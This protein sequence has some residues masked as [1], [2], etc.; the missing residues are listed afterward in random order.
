L[1][2]AF[3]DHFPGQTPDCIL[4]A[5]NR[6]MWGMATWRNVGC[7]TIIAPDLEDEVRVTISSARFG[8]T[9]LNRP[10]PEW[11]RFSA[12][13]LPVMADA[14]YVLSGGDI[15]LAGEEPAGPRYAYALGIATAALVCEVLG[16]PYDA[17]R[18]TELV[19]RVRRER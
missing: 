11:A 2:A 8:Q 5:P 10:L 13:V 14:G 6:E 3:F 12:G 15:A 17:E 16:E 9:S 4:Q 19:E 7:F 1:L 18:L